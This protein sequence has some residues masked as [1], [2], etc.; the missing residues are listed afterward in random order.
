MP[1]LRVPERLLFEY[2][3]NYDDRPMVPIVFQH[4]SRSSITVL[5]L[6]DSGASGVLLPS[7]LAGQLGVALEVPSSPVIGVTGVG[8]G[9]IQTL[10]ATVPDLDD[11]SFA[12]DAVFL[13][14][15]PIA[16]VGREPFFRGLD[17]A[18]RHPQGIMYF[19]PL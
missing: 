3:V 14:E 19:Q 8:Q 4:Q 12:V 17:V 5:C 11:H 7:E 13:P 2:V 18:F 16:L 9:W 10:S 1:R 15:L 6:V